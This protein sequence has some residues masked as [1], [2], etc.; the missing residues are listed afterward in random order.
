M[1]IETTFIS[2]FFYVVLCSLDILLKFHAFKS[3]LDLTSPSF[4]VKLY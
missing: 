3:L 1:N 4:K 2:R